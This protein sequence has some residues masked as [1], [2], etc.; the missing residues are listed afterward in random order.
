MNNDLAHLKK[1]QKT[2]VTVYSEADYSTNR[3]AS[4]YDREVMDEKYCNNDQ[5]EYSI[6]EQNNS[7]HHCYSVVHQS[8]N[9]DVLK[10]ITNSKRL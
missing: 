2:K 5:H 9:C 8:V 10:D 4:G 7:F 1:L 6:D 3:T